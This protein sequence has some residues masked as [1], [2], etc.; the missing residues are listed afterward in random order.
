MPGGPSPARRLQTSHKGLTSQDA[1]ERLQE[2]GPNK[3]PEESRS[4]ILTYLGVRAAHAAPVL[5]ALG[6]VLLPPPPPQHAAQACGNAC[7]AV[8]RCKDVPGRA[9]DVPGTSNG[10]CASAPGLRMDGMV[11]LSLP[12]APLNSGPL[13][14]MWNPLSWAMEAAAIIAI[15]LL[16]GS[17]GGGRGPVGPTAVHDP[18][19]ACARHG[20]APCQLSAWRCGSSCCAVQ[21]VLLPSAC[22]AAAPPTR[23]FT[24][25]RHLPTNTHR[26]TPTLR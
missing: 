1:A 18:G 13:Q 11:N 8:R 3:L 12:I 22:A 7:A 17:V 6:C 15:A 20:H 9:G 4:A 2:Y 26:T 16:V 24:Q 19:T 10:R 14:Y 23:T 21:A 5:H 25:H